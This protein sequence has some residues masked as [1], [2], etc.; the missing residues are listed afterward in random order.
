MK[1]QNINGTHDRE[2]KCGSWFKHWENFSGQKRPS[3][4]PAYGCGNT[5]LVGAHVQ[6]GG[7]S[8]DQSWYIYPL[9]AS[10]NKHEGE[11]EVSNSYKLVSANKKKTCEK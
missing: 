5:N 7:D 11:L 6:K 10:H 9:C 1:I 3:R 4:C 8:K 2:C